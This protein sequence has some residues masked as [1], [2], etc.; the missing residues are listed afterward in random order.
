VRFTKDTPEYETP[1]LL[2]LRCASMVYLM[3]GYYSKSESCYFDCLNSKLPNSWVLGWVDLP[4]I[5]IQE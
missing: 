3:Q 2:A 4:E 5:E 1:I